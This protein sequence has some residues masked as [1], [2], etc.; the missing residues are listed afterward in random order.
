MEEPASGERRR[1]GRPL[2][3]GLRASSVRLSRRCKTSASSGKRPLCLSLLITLSFYIHFFN[4]VLDDLFRRYALSKAIKVEDDAMAQSR[5]SDSLEVFQSNVVAT[6][7]QGTHLCGQNQRLQTAW[8]GSIAHKI[9]HLL[10]HVL[11][12]WMSCQQQTYGVLFH[13]R[14]YGYSSRCFY[15]LQQLFTVCYLFGTIGVCSHGRI[16]DLQQIF[17]IRE[18][19]Q[20]FQQ[21]AIKLSLWQWV[22]ALHFQRILGSQHEE[23]LW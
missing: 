18:A 14:R 2:G 23:G 10:W 8:T 11:L 16:D 9:P 12:V 7:E 1:P 5:K 13:M 21:K 19:H 3:M 4:N 20:N 17:G 6:F 22:G 15:E